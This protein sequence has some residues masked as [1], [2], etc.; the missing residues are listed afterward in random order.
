MKQNIK[1]Y[2]I[3]INIKWIKI[4]DKSRGTSVPIL[5]DIGTLTRMPSHVAVTWRCFWWRWSSM[6]SHE[7]V[8]YA[9]AES[10]SY[11]TK[12]HF[13]RS[14]TTANIYSYII[15]GLLQWY[16]WIWSLVGIS[17]DTRKL[18]S[19][20]SPTQ[21]NIHRY[22]CNNPIIQTAHAYEWFGTLSPFQQCLVI[23]GQWKG[24]HEGLCAI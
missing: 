11:S 7:K 13:L 1:F 8:S 9:F 6:T 21:V 23:S 10:D 17:M 16:R 15:K 20:D 22:Q 3:A 5:L 2:Y 18:A 24:E 4:C 19:F 14:Q 12:T